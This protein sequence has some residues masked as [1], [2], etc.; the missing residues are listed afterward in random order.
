M[1][2]AVSHP[3]SVY[4]S[5]DAASVGTKNTRIA[6]ANAAFGPA[7]KLMRSSSKSVM[8]FERYVMSSASNGITKKYALRNMNSFPTKNSGVGITSHTSK[9]AS[10][11]WFPAVDTRVDD[12]AA[13]IALVAAMANTRPT[14]YQPT[15][16]FFTRTD[17]TT[18]GNSTI[19]VITTKP[20]MA[21][22]TS[23]VLANSRND[24]PRWSNSRYATDTP[25]MNARK[26]GTE[27]SAS[28]P[29]VCAGYNSPSTYRTGMR[30]LD[31]SD[32]RRE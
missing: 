16:G 1:S 3:E 17:R 15:W 18:E 7:L 12:S 10:R 23:R 2:P 9:N 26:S 24:R 13:T 30:S 8:T 28:A 32:G 27:T 29:N 22:T 25:I 21:T 31:E 6:R 4:K 5:G 20:I 19:A 14:A 11:R